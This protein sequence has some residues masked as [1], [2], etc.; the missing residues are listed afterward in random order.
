M[1][2]IYIF[3]LALNRWFINCLKNIMPPKDLTSIMPPVDLN[4]IIPPIYLNNIMPPIS[5]III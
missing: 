4:N 1:I 3:G 5:L 2:L